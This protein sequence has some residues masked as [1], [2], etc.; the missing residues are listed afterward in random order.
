MPLIAVDG[1]D[2][3]GKTE[4]CEIL[5]DYIQETYGLDDEQIVISSD[6]K[7]SVFAERVR[8]LLVG[9]G[10]CAMTE[11]YLVLAARA[12]H[13][14]D[15]VKPALAAGKVVILDRY[16]QSTYAYQYRAGGVPYDLVRH[17]HN[18]ME[19]PMA[20]LQL[21]LVLPVEVARK[22][23]IERCGIDAIE[24]RSLKYQTVICNFFNAQPE[25][26]LDKYHFDQKQI[27]AERSR[28]EMLEQAKP[29]LARLFVRTV[30]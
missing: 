24:G 1:I 7:F 30:N 19:A 9:G 25:L 6:L 12:Q 23:I 5:A 16:I 11:L 18:A 4:F 29:V 14:H 27:D 3:A 2:G 8:A 13:L 21:I 22:R 15:V 28:Q 10:I 26:S 20:N 17:A